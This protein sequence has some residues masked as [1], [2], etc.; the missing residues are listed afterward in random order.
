MEKVAFNCTCHKISKPI[1]LSLAFLSYVFLAVSQPSIWDT[2]FWL[3]TLEWNLL[4]ITRTHAHT[5]IRKWIEI[6]A[7]HQW[8]RVGLWR[9]R[10]WAA[11][12]PEANRL[13]L[14]Q[15][16]E[17]IHEHDGLDELDITVLR[18]PVYV[19]GG[20]HDLPV[21][22]HVWWHSYKT[23]GE[24]SWVRATGKTRSKAYLWGTFLA[25]NH[26]PFHPNLKHKRNMAGRCIWG[27]S[28]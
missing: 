4:N 9:P 7:E 24:K 2:S 3:S 5:W 8:Y 27:F 21:H 1:F 26:K 16:L 28:P 12:R 22:W 19:Y 11:A 25:A 15:L 23:R 10:V 17:F 6:T 20:H 13:L 18:V 14:H